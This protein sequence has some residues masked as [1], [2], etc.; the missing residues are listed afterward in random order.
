MMDK[1]TNTPH[2]DFSVEEILQEARL[3]REQ[4]G[5]EAVPATVEDANPA[6]E[7]AQAKP[8]RNTGKPVPV[9]REPKQPP[10][11]RKEPEPA[12]KVEEPAVAA[13]KTERMGIE[14]PRA[15]PI[16]WADQDGPA[17][18]APRKMTWAERRAE[19][20]RVKEER[21]RLKKQSGTFT[22]EEED[23]YYGLQ[24][25]PLEEYKQQYEKVIQP[26]K[27]EAG[28]RADA[29]QPAK[30]PAQSAGDKT[31]S[32][33]SYLFDASDE[34][35]DAEIAARFETLH[36]DR[37]QRIEEVARRTGTFRLS[38]NT[39]EIQF[40]NRAPQQDA[41]EK[42]AAPPQPA[43]AAKAQ[44]EQKKPAEQKPKREAAK[45]VAKKP[46]QTP[47]VLDGFPVGDETFE[48]PAMGSFARP[49]QQK[50][51]ERAGASG[52]PE[53]GET[54][55]FPAVGGYAVPPQIEDTA[56]LEPVQPPKPTEPQTP[57]EPQKPAEPAHPAKTAP[58]KPQEMPA[59]PVSTPETPARPEVQ[60]AVTPIS[61]E[62]SAQAADTYEAGPPAQSRPIGQ[63]LRADYRPAGVT[64][65]HVVELH[66]YAEVI[67]KEAK[68]YPKPS[69]FNT[70]PLKLL[71]TSGPE[72]AE[73]KA[74]EDGFVEIEALLRPKGTPPPE[75]PPARTELP[76]LEKEPEEE[77]FPQ[78]APKKKKKFSLMGE[79]EPDNDPQDHLPEEPDELDDYQKPSDAPSVAHELGSS[80]REITLRLAVTGI[81][82]VLLLI[83]GVLGEM[84]G[85]LP[86]AVRI[87]IPT[88]TYLILN[89][90]FLGITSLFCIVTILNGVKSLARLQASSD[91]G[92]AVA[93]IAALIQSAA[94]LFAPESVASS[95]VH[96][97]A[98]LAAAALFLNTAGK[99]SMIK[100]I[101]H[102]F[103][104]VASP[105]QKYAVQYFDDHNIA[106]QMAKG[107]VADT[108]AIGYQNK[109]DFLKHF[110]SLS[111]ENDPSDNS[112]HIIA[113]IGFILSLVLC[114]V[115][116]YLNRDVV[117]AIT[118]FAAATCI[119]V[120]MMNMLSVNLPLARL[121][122]IA[123][124]CGAMVV[125]YPA[126]EHFSTANA[127]VLDA[128]DLFPKGTVI[129]NGIKTF[130]GQRI[131]DAI[132]DATALMCATGGPL[133]SLF[134]Q[135]IK[136][137]TDILPKVEN[138][139]Y[140]DDRGVVGWV[141]G[142]RI[143]VGN[144]ELMKAY[145]IEPPSRDY[146]EKYL[147]G[148]K[149]V[150]YLASSGDLVAMF[151]V[152]YNS[153]R[154]RAAELRRMEDN[155]I[156][157]I[158]RTRDPNVTPRL[159]A[160]VFDL[161][162]HGIRVLPE[163]LG[164]A[165]ADRTKEPEE[166]ADA[167]LATKGRPTA[168]MRML[169][170]CVRQRSNISVSVALQIV[171]VVLGFL[172]VAFLACYS[173]LKQLSTAALLLFE[174]FWLVA[175]LVVPRLRKP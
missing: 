123:T 89:L 62:T 103:R 96:S 168:M 158:V 162:E 161:D 10:A 135:I 145:G 153:D 160:Q 156:S 53:E 42:P 29:A 17:E 99:F 45:P 61:A 4:Q 20:K 52:I 30:R 71:E 139:T 69:K 57:V 117:G 114:I 31:G 56:P 166:R 106:L 151:I 26:D 141:S 128:T 131:D 90:V 60:P 98:A 33:F 87:A 138:L 110:L 115:Y 86:E 43:P 164:E 72:S 125:G 175:V 18:E 94:L 165:Y 74:G 132:V 8:V 7:R 97:Y 81:A 174:L 122:K 144:R 64:P 28:E 140:E 66:D 80:M 49:A 95:G 50:N 12:R 1:K 32:I 127:V 44:P 24:L 136:T 15:G 150:V 109:A 142:R 104:F 25:K 147:L 129:L 70:A 155:G 88:Q 47:P 107:C 16:Q 65:L 39:I 73:E 36:E 11:E 3:L 55:E 170:A 105:D 146:E 51:A 27:A 134:S 21:R 133:S 171:A 137:R 40:P 48:F 22:A 143:L 37:K 5:E 35:L 85:I 13:P 93:A 159:L 54:F 82:T 19:K 108:P 63:V 152:L 112:S 59:A 167:L 38:Q 34:E 130:G 154:R 14:P 75:E 84:T 79:E 113:P 118:A 102:N 46:E 163:R 83:F 172:L 67:L 2:D 92:V 116:Y 76:T 58:V 126:V 119:S 6:P 68:T 149:Q 101:R 111:Y 173:G 157:L 169:T 78:P 23:I 148:G 77:E 121:S 120:P 124:R 91:S 100:R 41:A 9:I